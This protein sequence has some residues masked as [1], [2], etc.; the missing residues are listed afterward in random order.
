MLNLAQ[1]RPIW[2]ILLTIFASR[3]ILRELALF[4]QRE[5][6]VSY[7]V[8]FCNFL[9][10]KFLIL[11]SATSQWWWLRCSV[12]KLH[13]HEKNLT[14]WNLTSTLPLPCSSKTGLIFTLFAKVHIAFWF[15]LSIYE[16]LSSSILYVILT[17]AVHVSKLVFIPKS[18]SRTMRAKPK[19]QS[20][21]I[22][23]KVHK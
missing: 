2:L 13:L 16:V 7:R 23:I 19:N 12:L 22:S 3:N 17:V 11:H 20:W 10:R 9:S 8:L 1:Y 14:F 15:I 4:C 5:L 21:L 18:N 6:P